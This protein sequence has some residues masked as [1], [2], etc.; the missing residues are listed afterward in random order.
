[1]AIGTALPLPRFSGTPPIGSGQ[2]DLRK[3][4]LVLPLSMVDNSVL[5][6]LVVD[7]SF[8]SAKP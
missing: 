3:C 2:F 5:L 4:L 1:M 7:N 6:L 8:C